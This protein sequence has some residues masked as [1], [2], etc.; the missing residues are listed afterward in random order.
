VSTLTASDALEIAERAI[1]HVSGDGAEAVVATERSGFARYAGSEVHQP[2]LIENASVQL[3]VVRDGRSGLATTNRTDDEGLTELARRAGE[4]LASTGE[5]PDEPAPAPPADP[6]EIAG[7]DEATADLGADDQARL[8]AAAIAAAGD[9]ELYGYFTSGVCDLAIAS[10]TGLRLAQRTTDATCLALAAADGASGYA[11][12]TAWRAADLDPAAVAAEAA[13]KAA[14]TRGAQEAGA[15]RYRAVLEPYAV[16]ELLEYFSYD[17]C[18]GL[19]LLEE[20]SFFSGRIGRQ[21]FDEKV[22]LVD[23][24]LDPHGLPKAFDYEGTP[25]QRVPLVERGVIRGAV[26]DRATAAR[27]GRE[28]TGHGLPADAR[29]YGPLPTALTLAPGEA[30]SVE[31]LAELVG[32]GIYVT[33]LHYLGVVDPRAGVLTGM[34]RDGTFRIRGGKIAEPL[35]NLRFTVSMPELLADVPGL[36]RETRLVNESD[37]YDERWAYAFRVPAIATG[38]FNVTGSGSGP[39]L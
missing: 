36:T 28:S 10:T 17:T 4:V 11:L 25:K 23:D 30:E 27:A 26:W 8:A 32:D 3:R 12:A 31:E 24:A 29:S 37:F 2:T 39:G 14:R 7:Y 38:C 35:V 13:A 16:S 33:R 1:A 18:N 15:S 5:N 20:R 6:P 21:A 9:F 19:A 34:T 22:T